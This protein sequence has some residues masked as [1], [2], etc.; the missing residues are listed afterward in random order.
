M[1]RRVPSKQRNTLVQRERDPGAPARLAL[2]LFGGLLLAGGFVYAGG[3]HFAALRLGYETEKLRNS[4]NAAREDQRRLL[5]EREAAASPARLELAARR[6]GMQP[7]QASQIDPLKQSSNPSNLKPIANS[8]PAPKPA[9]RKQA[10][11]ENRTRP[12]DR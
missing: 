2:L 11:P 7:M 4:L 5:L 8:N 3:R 6:L 10:K 9:A 1:I 12:A